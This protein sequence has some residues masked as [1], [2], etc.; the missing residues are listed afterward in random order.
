MKLNS[1]GEPF[2]PLTLKKNGQTQRQAGGLTL[3]RDP[4][5]SAHYIYIKQQ[6]VY[7]QIRGQEGIGGGVRACTWLR[8]GKVSMDL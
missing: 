8:T 7:I 3:D 4:F 1:G 5:N 6:V 2:P